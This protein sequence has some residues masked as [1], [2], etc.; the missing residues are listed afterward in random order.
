MRHLRTLL[1]STLLVSLIAATAMAA[2]AEQFK[3]LFDGKSIEG[4]VRR[5]G[6]AEYRVENGEIVGVSQT[7]TPNTFLCTPRDYGDFILE[8]ELKV[9][10]GLNS[11][12]QIRS[13]AFD[14]RKSVTVE[15][16][17]GEEKEIRIPAGRV[18]GYQVEIDPSDRAYSGGIYDEARRGWL[19]DLSGDEHKEARAAFKPGQ[20]NT[21]RIECR[22][23]SIKTWINGVPV[24]DLTDDMTPK[25]F[26]A[27][28]VHSIGNNQDDAGKEVRWR[29]LKIAELEPPAGE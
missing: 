5:G 15:G 22:G 28:Q 14:E 17:D 16:E 3:P 13:Q 7:N 12:I 21:Y 29:N 6:K 8:V 20:W 4:W 9:D 26:I 1:L 2:L 27:L 24:A 23:P 18:H 11:G 10:E 25:G 19:Y